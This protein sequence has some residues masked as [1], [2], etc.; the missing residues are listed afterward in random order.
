[1]PY[2]EVCYVRDAGIPE[3]EVSDV[4]YIYKHSHYP[5]RHIVDL[6][7]RGASWTQLYTWCGIP[8]DVYYR[9]YREIYRPGPP[10]GN[11]Y[12]YYKNHGR[13]DYYSYDRDRRDGRGNRYDNWNYR[14][15]NRDNRY[16]NWD[17]RYDNRGDKHD[18]RGDQDG[19]R[20]DRGKVHGKHKGWNR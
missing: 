16:D 7:L 14:Y 17:D 10:Y 5:L 1:M 19:G 2:D 4:L 9:S 8:Q 18:N 20:G 13:P 3:Y 15:D 12:G 6:R 11:A